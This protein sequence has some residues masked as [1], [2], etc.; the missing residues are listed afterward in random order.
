[1]SAVSD[2]IYSTS[3]NSCSD[4]FD[5]DNEAPIPSPFDF[6]ET[7]EIASSERNSPSSEKYTLIL[8][9]H[10]K[11]KDF[12]DDKIRKQKIQALLTTDTIL[13]SRD[14]R[15]ILP[16]DTHLIPALFLQ[17]S[18][19]HIDYFHHLLPKKML[20]FW[21]E[22]AGFMGR[23][24]SPEY[25]EAAIVGAK[26]LDLSYKTGLSCIEGGNCR[27]FTA[28]DGQPKAIVGYNSVLL[29]LMCLQD[30]LY[31]AKNAEQLKAH[32]RELRKEPIDP[33]LIRIGRN[34]HSFLSG[35]KNCPIEKDPKDPQNPLWQS[36]AR[37]VGGMLRMAK[38]QIAEDLK[39]PLER[40]AFVF[41]EQFHIDLE[42][43]PVSSPTGDLVFLH[44]EEL[45]FKVQQEIPK[46][47][48]LA[49]KT[50]P[51][52]L[53]HFSINQEIVAHNIQELAKISCKAIRVPGA[54]SAYFHQGETIS[55]SYMI[56][57]WMKDEYHFFL[58][59]SDSIQIDRTLLQNR[60]VNFM[61]GLYFSEPSPYFITSAPPKGN[62]VIDTLIKAFK[63]AVREAYSDLKISFIREVV[64]NYLI[65]SSGG[66]HC[67]T[68]VMKAS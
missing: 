54:L 39:I 55:Y 68:S 23:G 17:N 51:Y 13:W 12:L 46:V 45:M 30:R 24:P 63:K 2:E 31:F 8:V 67:M 29:T 11:V 40:I 7:E 20:H 33:D 61:N 14:C 47:P 66:L 38:E 22:N 1:M 35:K 10:P 48:F 37:E 44:D 65:H 27:I 62:L 5:S 57:N 58:K 21:K 42:L 6:D 9:G 52:T 4:P 64:P 53:S 36:C 41:Q 25:R 43:F 59:H 28:S 32:K 34:Y 26:Q 56:Q 60:I 50:L 19:K 3:P 15:V 16:D 49:V 18:P